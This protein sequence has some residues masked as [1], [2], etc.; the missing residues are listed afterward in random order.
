MPLNIISYDSLG[1]GK[2][3]IISWKI[4]TKLNFINKNLMILSSE[5]SKENK[6]LEMKKPVRKWAT[7]KRVRASKNS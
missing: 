7:K 3:N 1:Y 2:Y 4:L 6:I 5:G